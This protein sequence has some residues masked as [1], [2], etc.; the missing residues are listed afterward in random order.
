MK[1]KINYY[2]FCISI[3]LL[4]SNCSDKKNVVEIYLLNNRIKSFEGKPIEHILNLDTLDIDRKLYLQN[5]SLD[6]KDSCFIHSGKFNVESKDL[7]EKPFISDNEI[8]K[9]NTETSE[10]IF[11][12]SAIEKIQKLEPNSVKSIQFSICVDKKPTLNGY[13]TYSFSSNIP[14]TNFI[15]FHN[16]KNYE[17]IFKRKKTNKF[18][19]NYNNKCVKYK[20]IL[21]D[22]K[23]YPLLLKAFENSDRL[24]KASS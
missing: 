15:F 11:S 2:L 7:N 6:L 12:E 20:P 9:F 16:P 17:S 13:F 19:L 22:L 3:L 24:I 18:I 1:T 14:T 23:N 5:A 10:I 8:L 21:N 4:F